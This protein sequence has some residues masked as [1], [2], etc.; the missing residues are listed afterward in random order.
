MIKKKEK[1][2]KHI[3]KKKS[4]IIIIIISIILVLGFIVGFIIYKEYSKN[5]FINDIK[6][7]YSNKVEVIK[8]TK[9]YDKNKNIIGTVNKGY[10]FDI[11]NKKIQSIDDVFF[12]IKDTNYY[13]YYDSVKKV[14]EVKKDLKKE[15]YLVFNNNIECSNIKF[16]IDNKVVLSIKDK[17]SLPIEYTDENYYYVYYLNRM[18][19][20]KKDDNIKLKESSNT[21]EKESD[22]I[23]VINYNKIYNKDNDSCKDDSCIELSFVKD[24]LKYL[25]DSNYYTITIDEYNSWIKGEIRL[26]TNAILLTTNNNDYIDELNKEFNLKIQNISNIELKF[27][28]NNT[29]NTKEKKESINRYNIKNDSTIDD[30][31]RMVLGETIIKKAKIQAT[32]KGGVAVLNYHFFYDPSIGEACNENICLETSTFRKQLDYLKNNGYKTLRMDEFIKWMYGEISIPEKSVLITVDDGAMGTSTING[33]KLIPILEEY[34]M[35]ATLFLI[36]AWWDKSNYQSK[37]LEVE[38]HGDDIHIRGDCGKNKI[39]CLTKEQLVNDF[40]ISKGKLNTN[41]A[42]CYPFYSY[43]NTAIEAIQELGFKVAFIG[44]SRKAKQSDNKYLIPRYPIHKTTSFESFIQ[45]VS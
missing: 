4:I 20:V 33:N 14:K 30:F 1:I 31:K 7:H 38:S 22:Y 11:S 15:N 43:N 39:H 5:K 19:E 26:K 27:N 34:Q 40:N 18:L 2:K 6:N 45:M 32:S 17:I 44:G 37:F 16:Y 29:K 28:D 12:K 3:L 24:N 13:L 10:T 36:T 23:S 41:K 25:K 8:N 9:L 35:N 21:D 42:F